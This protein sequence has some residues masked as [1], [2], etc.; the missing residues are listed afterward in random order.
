MSR[1]AIATTV[2]VHRL[3]ELRQILHVSEAAMDRA[4]GIAYQ[5]YTSR[6][7]AH[8]AKL[9]EALIACDQRYWWPH[10]LLAA[11]LRHL[12]RPDEALAAVNRGLEHEPDQP[13]LLLMQRELAIILGRRDAALATAKPERTQAVAAAPTLKLSVGL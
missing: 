10:S 5:L 2:P 3:P 11:A 7:Y 6:R 4:M 1:T 8:A 13:K 12:D 9:C